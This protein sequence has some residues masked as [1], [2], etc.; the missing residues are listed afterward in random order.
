[1][2]AGLE[3]AW[4]LR[5]AHGGSARVVDIDRPESLRM[6][7]CPRP[8]PRVPTEAENIPAWYYDPS[9]NQ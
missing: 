8:R 1:M 9:P 2:D 7:H 4:V 6:G 5:S 3:D